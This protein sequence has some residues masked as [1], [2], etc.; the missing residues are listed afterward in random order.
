MMKKSIW[1]EEITLNMYAV[2]IRAPKHT[3]KILIGLKVDIDSKNIIIAGLYPSPTFQ[4]CKD[5]PEVAEL[6]LP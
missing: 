1:Q 4:Q 6:N 5:H 2:S 3:K